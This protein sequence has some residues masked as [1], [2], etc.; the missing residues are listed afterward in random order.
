MTQNMNQ[1]SKSP[2][3]SSRELLTYEPPLV[4]DYGTVS[5]LTRGSGG[6]AGSDM[7][8]A[9]GAGGGSGGS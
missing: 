8:G 5:A 2:G 6:I 1:T 9:S 4:I 7:W 3:T